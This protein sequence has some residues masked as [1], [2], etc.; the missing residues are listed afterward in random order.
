MSRIYLK[1]YQWV[2]R[3]LVELLDLFPPR[4]IDKNEFILRKGNVP[5]DFCPHPEGSIWVHGASLGE[6]ITM[7]PFLTELARQYGR[8]R[9]VCTS[10]TMDGLKQ[11]HRDAICGFATLLPIELPAYSSPFIDRI[12]PK[13]MLISETEIW[14]LLLSTL[15][16]KNIPYG[17]INGRVNE[18][19]VRLMRIFWP[20]FS[21]AVENCA[22]VFPQEKHYKRRFKILGIAPEKLT[23]LGCFKY[24]FIDDKPDIA[25]LRQKLGVPDTR[26]IICFGSTHPGEEEQILDA[27]EPLWRKLDATV[28]LA[29][30]HVK[31]V[32][33]VEKLL[34]SRNLD[35]SKLS[36]QQRRA[37]HVVIVDS[38]GD[39][40][41]IYAA[42]ALAY[43][44]GSL[45]KHGGHNL[46]EP[47]SFSVP[48]L[49]GPHTFNFR[50]E[51][52]ALKK[53]KAV[54]LVNNSTE[55]NAALTDWLN[56]PQKY[57]EMG[58]RAKAVL[59]RMSGSSYRTI[60]M[61]Q[62][63]NYLPEP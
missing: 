30:R 32:A 34:K 23:T 41:T 31:R 59:D 48:L 15:K 4:R 52:M 24:D 47:T 20:L 45:I 7:R 9:I 8:E 33:E 55:L 39:L 27:L 29:P 12:K 63:L 43:V 2:L 21:K 38:L 37:G 13:L 14:P 19:S 11:L 35:Y 18:K 50:Y 36:Q 10:T 54:C 53:A 26:Q 28:I 6:A 57:A 16:R 3:A 51:M 1:S 5:D 56:N 25:A 22:F 49:T 40:R 60:E 42:S 44:G 61:L 62:K 46:M 58:L 17:I